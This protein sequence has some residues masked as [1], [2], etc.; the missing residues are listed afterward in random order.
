MVGCG[1][2][3]AYG[4]TEIGAAAEEATAETIETEFRIGKKAD[5]LLKQTGCFFLNKMTL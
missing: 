4:G 5:G 2:S 3:A 1:R